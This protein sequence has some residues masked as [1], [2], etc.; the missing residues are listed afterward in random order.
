MCSCVS[1]LFCFFFFFS[2]RRRHTRCSRDWSSD[3]CSS[4]LRAKLQSCPRTTPPEHSHGHPHPRPASARH[5]RTRVQT[6]L[7]TT[8]RHGQTHTNSVRRGNTQSELQPP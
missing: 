2:S 6:P 1:C 7:E 5:K 4:D 3:V 8:Q